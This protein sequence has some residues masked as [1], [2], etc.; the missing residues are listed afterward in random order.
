VG[1][2]QVGPQP[3]G[4]W[5]VPMPPEMLAQAAAASAKITAD[6][7]EWNA[8]IEKKRRKQKK[9]DK[10]EAGGLF[11]TRTAPTLN[12][13]HLLPLLRACVGFRVWV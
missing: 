2:P 13:Q 6:L 1:R 3:P 8:E 7:A 12:A 11:R 10:K 4:G 9:A 5:G